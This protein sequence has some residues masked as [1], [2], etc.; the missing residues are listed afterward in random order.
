MSNAEAPTE[1]AEKGK[2]GAQSEQEQK[3]AERLKIRLKFE[4]A[5]LEAVADA[6]ISA[7]KEVPF[8]DRLTQVLDGNNALKELI[9]QS[10]QTSQIAKEATSVLSHGKRI[11]K[12]FVIRILQKAKKLPRRDRGG[13]IIQPRGQR[14]C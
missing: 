3:K 5:F 4:Q 14:S 12:K 7:T 11:A 10:P 2:H 1:K 13:R 6:E 8:P 9:L